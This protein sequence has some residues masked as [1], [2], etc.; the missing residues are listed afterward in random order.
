M[1]TARRGLKVIKQMK[2]LKRGVK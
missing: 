2:K 1:K